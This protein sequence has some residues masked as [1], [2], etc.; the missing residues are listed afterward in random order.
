MNKTTIVPCDEYGVQTEDVFDNSPVAQFYK[1]DCTFGDTQ[2]DSNERRYSFSR[3]VD[4]VREFKSITFYTKDNERVNVPEKQLS[5]SMGNDLVF[6]FKLDEVYDIPD[7]ALP[8]CPVE[9]VVKSKLPIR[10]MVLLLTGKRFYDNYRR[11]LIRF[12]AKHYLRLCTDEY[13]LWEHKIYR[14][15]DLTSVKRIQLGN[16]DSYQLSYW[17]E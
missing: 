4:I 2:N 11:E 7:F 14:S 10:R 6:P 15:V 8:Y 5:I 3:Y 9:L 17:I 13:F 1:I 12:S 16:P